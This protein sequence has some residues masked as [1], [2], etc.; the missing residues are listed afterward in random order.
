LEPL[1]GVDWELLQ[2]MT[3]DKNRRST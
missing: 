3:W 2:I 1:G